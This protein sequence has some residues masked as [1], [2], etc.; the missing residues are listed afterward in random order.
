M[1]HVASKDADSLGGFVLAS[2]HGHQKGGRFVQ[3]RARLYRSTIG[4]QSVAES[5]S[6]SRE[7]FGATYV[8]TVDMFLCNK[9]SWS[10]SHPFLLFDTPRTW[11]EISCRSKRGHGKGPYSFCQGGWSCHDDENEA[12]KQQAQERGS[13]AAIME[14]GRD[15]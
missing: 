12:C 9:R 2:R 8:K 15:V 5:S 10:H 7:Y 6:K 13:C 3:Q 11:T 1:G 14:K 4:Y